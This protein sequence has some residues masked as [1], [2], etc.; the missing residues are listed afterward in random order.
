MK[1]VICSGERPQGTEP[2]VGT[3]NF[4]YRLDFSWAKWPDPLGATH[5]LTGSFDETG[6]L[7]VATE[8]P[9]HP[10]AVFSP[11]GE[12]ICSIGA[13]LFS[14][15][16]STY[17]TP[18]KT[19]LVA[20]SSKDYHVIR[21]ITQEGA[22]VRDFGVKGQP[23]DSGYDF[24]YLQVLQE[25]GC[26]P[27]DPVWNRKPEANAR[28]DSV[29]K[30]G[31]PFCRPCAMVMNQAGEYFAADGYGNDAVHKFHADGSYAF[32]WGG[33]GREPGCFRLV[34]DV[35]IDCRGRVWVSD[36]E[37][38]RVQ[39][40]DQNGG[41][42]AIVE[43][44]LMRIGAVWT[45]DRLAYIGE[46]DGGVTILD[47]DFN[48]KAQIGWKG[49]ALHA[50]GITGDGKGNLFLFTNKKNETNILRLVHTQ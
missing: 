16:H 47:L 19:I 20:D 15:A 5:A 38:S 35:W 13:G 7:Y 18:N 37:N 33:P 41:L 43:G 34:H 25:K 4:C 39:V 46:L 40:F 2:V 3:G 1:R 12:W 14:K 22:L 26:V 42:L 49:S 10:I 36:R 45:D 8:N 27:E 17:L 28:L 24:N 50:H 11:E 21:E 31:S 30:M 6:R 23:G 9:Q 29:K 48:V 44:N 32:S